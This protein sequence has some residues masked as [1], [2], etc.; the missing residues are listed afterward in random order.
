MRD[1][2]KQLAEQAQKLQD[3]IRE[4]SARTDR[5][6]REFIEESDLKTSIIHNH[7][8]FP[9]EVVRFLATRLRENKIP[10]EVGFD[11]DLALSD[12]PAARQ[13]RDNFRDSRPF[14]FVAFPAEHMKKARD[15]MATTNYPIPEASE[16]EQA[17]ERALA[18][19][20]S[21]EEALK[22]KRL[23]VYSLYLAVG[24]FFVFLFWLL[25]SDLM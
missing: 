12:S 23:L 21:L 16:A 11:K 3:D 7:G 19:Q 14:Y 8:Y 2:S 5:E 24:G 17:A 22:F 10:C 15:I 25:V 4:M 6:N 20:R 13:L 9:K 1:R 18:R